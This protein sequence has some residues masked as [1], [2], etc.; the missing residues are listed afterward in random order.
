MA[1]R[2]QLCWSQ[3]ENKFVGYCDYDND[4]NFEKKET[5][6]KEVLVFMLVNLKGKWKWP[7][8]YF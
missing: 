5:E 8:A 1:I 2:Q 7:I 4:L 6:A 3:T